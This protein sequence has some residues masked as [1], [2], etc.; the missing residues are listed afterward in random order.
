MIQSCFTIKHYQNILQQIIRSEYCTKVFSDEIFHKKVILVRHD[1]DHDINAAFRMALLEK[2]SDIKATYLV[3]LRTKNYNIFEASCC[4][5]IRHISDMGHE[6]GLHFSLGDHPKEQNFFNLSQLIKEDIDYLSSCLGIPIKVF[7]FHNP[8]ENVDFQINVPGYIN[9][10]A[11]RYFND[12][13]YI[14]DSGFDWKG[15]DPSTRIKKLQKNIVQLLVHPCNFAMA[16]ASDA[17]KIRNFIKSEARSL[18]IYNT[19]QCRSFWN[20]EFNI[21]EFISSIKLD[22]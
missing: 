14:S 19:K 21:E 13:E 7:G 4:K 11:S 3:L 17:E 9:T 8:N 6:I 12:A 22:D 1:I 15:E 16:F 18:A 5:K 10:Y 20:D 2:E